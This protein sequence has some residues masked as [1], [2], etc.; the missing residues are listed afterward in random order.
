V[1]TSFSRNTTGDINREKV[2]EFYDLGSPLYLEVYGENLHDGYYITGK[3]TRQEAQENL[4]RFIA[5]KARIRKGSRILDVGCGMGGSS[6]W[7]AQHFKA[8]TVGITISPA[9]LEIAR[10]LAKERRVDS[11]FLLMNAEDMRFNESFDVIWTV[12]SSTHFENQER[13]VKSTSAF[14]NPGGKLVIFDWMA[15]ESIQD[16]LNDPYLKPVNEGMLLASLCSINSYLN[17]L[18][19]YGYRLTFVEDITDRTFKTWDDALAVIKDPSIWKLATRINKQDVAEILHFFKSLRSM[20]LA[21]KKG[22][23]RSGVIVAEKI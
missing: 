2:R 23:M 16:I 20:R 11:T 14:L 18:I 4:T 9:Q 21:M 5:E 10:N 8:S 3:E 13:F 12:A 17:W 22:K 6:I 7:L 15:S 1:N 19:Q